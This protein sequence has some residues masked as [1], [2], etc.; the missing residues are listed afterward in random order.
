MDGTVYRWP[1]AGGRP[2]ALT[3]LS[4]PATAVRFSPD[5]RVLAAGGYDGQVRLWD[6]ATGREFASCRGPVSLNALAFSADGRRVAGASRDL[7]KLWDADTGQEILTLR[8]LGVRRG[9]DFAF[10]PRVAF[11]GDGRRLAANYA[12]GA[13][14]LIWDA[15]P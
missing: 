8:P 12:Q 3:R 4:T 13:N 11:S 9:G 15:A 5:G 14:V 10:L 1:V 6:A 2:L 7:V